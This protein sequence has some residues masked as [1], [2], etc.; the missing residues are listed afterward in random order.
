MEDEKPE[1]LSKETLEKFALID[2]EIE[3]E[4]DATEEAAHGEE[5]STPA[6]KDPRA[7]DAAM[8]E[9]GQIIGVKEAVK[10]EAQLEEAEE[11]EPEGEEKEEVESEP[12]AKEE[13]TLPKRLIQAGYRGGFTKEDILAL[14]DRAEGVLSKLADHADKIS[15]ERGE[16]G[17][18]RKTEVQT[19]RERPPEKLSFGELDEFENEKFGKVEKFYNALFDEVT[20][21]KSAEAKRQQEHIDSTVDGFLDKRT[22][23]YPELGNS[24]S[25]TEAG[26]AVRAQI[27]DVAEN[28]QIG[29]QAKGWPVSLEIAL[30]QAFSIYEGKNVKETIRT[31]L[32]D[33]ADKRKKQFTSRPSRRRTEQKFSSARQKAMESYRKKAA[34]MN[35]SVSGD[36]E[37]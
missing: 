26:Y 10:P 9:D 20:T 25:L 4:E 28:I 35:L 27:Y 23:Q 21:L 32:V 24:K 33:E 8:A 2:T 5:E 19:Q 31:K 7:D 37:F 16:I 3:A 30:E 6:Y 1:G 18:R 13:L 14:G 34:S 22:E 11:E 29:S 36:E 17:R 15:S 12:T